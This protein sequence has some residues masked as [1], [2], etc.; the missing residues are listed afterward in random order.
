MKF[1]RR[2]AIS[3][4]VVGAALAALSFPER[5]VEVP[6]AADASGAS[7]VASVSDQEA[8]RWDEDE[9]WRSLEASFAQAR[10]VDCNTADRD[11]SRRIAELNGLIRRLAD[12]RTSAEDPRWSAV[13][14]MVFETAPLLAA[15]PSLAAGFVSVYAELRAA[16]KEQSVHWD[17]GN[18][19]TRDRMYRLLYGG[20]A[21]IEEVLLQMDPEEATALAL[22]SGRD[23][24]S[25]TPSAVVRGV[26]VHSGDILV[27]RG[28]FPTS[29]LIARGSDYPGN[30]SHVALVH[31][32]RHGEPAVIEAHIESG[33]TV[34]SVDQYFADKKMRIML[35]RPRRDLPQL[36][37]DPTGPHVAASRMRTRAFNA[38]VPYDFAMDYRSP[39][40]LFCSEVASAAYR[41]IDVTLWMGISSISAD[42]L[43]R[44]LSGFGVRNFE[45][46]EPSDLEYDPQLVVVAEWRD[47]NALFRDHI[48]NAVVDAMLEGAESGDELTYPAPMLPLARVAKGYSM[49]LNELRRVGPVPE[50]MTAGAALRNRTYTRRHNELATEVR[51]DAEA[52]VSAN[53]YRP[54]YW[55]LVDLARAARDRS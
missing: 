18:R 16:V 50:G 52:F 39:D 6:S 14:I 12:G 35:L 19:A 34:T 13:E 33:L 49:V 11:A 27:S 29:A 36:E 30:F 26:R 55:V 37:Q 23:E 25:E 28:G 8:F 45:T 38:H 48:H 5:R 17:L 32:N 46:Q 47:P 24:P 41:E 54:P 2:S 1:I 22:I 20:R 42:G 10:G 21:A 31:V 40:R 43:R 51:R 44:W 53:G 4:I 9:L 7:P 3:L 15:C